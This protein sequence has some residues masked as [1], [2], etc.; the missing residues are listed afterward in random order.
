M[1]KGAVAFALVL[2]LA[3]LGSSLSL[4]KNELKEEKTIN[5]GLG[6]VPS[7][8]N[9][10][11]PS[12]KAKKSQVRHEGSG[13]GWAADLLPAVFFR[14]QLW[15][16]QL[17]QILGILLGAF[18]AWAFGVFASFFTR[19]IL[20]RMAALTQ[21]KWD[22][23]LVGATRVPLIMVFFALGFLV[24]LPFLSLDESAKTVVL[25]MLKIIVILGVGWFLVRLVDVAAELLLGMF[26]KRDDEMGQA[27]VPMVRKIFKPLMVVLVLVFALQNAGMN[28]AGLLA[29]LGIGGLALALAAKTTVENL[30]GGITIAIDRPFKVGDLIKVG[31][32]RGTVEEVGIRSTRIRTWERT[33][34]TIPNGQ[35]ADAQVENLARREKLRETITVGVQYD[36]S[37]DQIRYIIDEIKRYFISRGDIDKGFLVRLAKFD[38][39]SKNIDLVFYVLTNDWNTFTGVREEILMEIG[40][41]V[42]R[43]GAEF[44][45]PSRSIYAGKAAEANPEKARKAKAIVEERKAAGELCIP[46]IPQEVAD[47]L[48]PKIG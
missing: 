34:V 43:A 7:D 36:T 35:M 20:G 47:K 40:E 28:V 25:R 11:N 14:V 37:L 44:A 1:N 16:I 4:A 33:V 12:A 21:N 10:Q 18:A 32:V 2:F 39:S 38:D 9:L 46:E 13:Y 8:S 42:R 17:W 41:I 23:V 29:G 48:K 19:K 45:F 5:A 3:F 15:G 22:D 24:V 27:M 6:E 30:L 31:D 26:K